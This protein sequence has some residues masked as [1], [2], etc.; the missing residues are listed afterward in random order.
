MVET[1]P[2]RRY[3]AARIPD[4]RDFDDRFVRR[5]GVSVR[6]NLRDSVTTELHP[7]SFFVAALRQ[8]DPVTTAVLRRF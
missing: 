8:C 1:K 6:A 2:F 4:G 7:L 5:N 3:P